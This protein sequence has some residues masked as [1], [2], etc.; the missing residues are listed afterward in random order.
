MRKFIEIA[1]IA[2]VLGSMLT[3][4]ALWQSNQAQ[5]AATVTLSANSK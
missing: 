2:L 1:A 5:A 4:P 3:G